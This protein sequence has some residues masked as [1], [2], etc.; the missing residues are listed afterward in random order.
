MSMF[1]VLNLAHLL[2]FSLLQVYVSC[3]HLCLKFLKHEL[4]LATDIS[5]IGIL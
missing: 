1:E 5:Q 3:F 4:G 2:V